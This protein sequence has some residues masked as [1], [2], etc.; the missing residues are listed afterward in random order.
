MILAHN[1]LSHK[2]L[3]EFETNA[4]NRNYLDW[5][6]ILNP[7][8]Q[9]SG[10]LSFLVFLKKQPK[11]VEKDVERFRGAPLKYTPSTEKSNSQ[12]DFKK[13]NLRS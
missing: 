7:L 2:S 13:I 4:L 3:I 8:K 11:N 6:M 12:N 1:M 9:K 5:L 10:S